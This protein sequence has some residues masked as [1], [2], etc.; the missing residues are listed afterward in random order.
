MSE[1]IFKY[2]GLLR[3]KKSEVVNIDF[4][5]EDKVNWLFME[6][7]FHKYSFIY[8]IQNPKSANFDEVFRIKMKFLMD[9]ID[10]IIDFNKTYL[11]YRGEEE[12]GF[13]HS[14]ERINKNFILE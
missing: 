10:S 7:N 6:N 11:V 2:T 5:F 1:H 12:I 8:E 3:I 13:L 14:I 4:P 9:G